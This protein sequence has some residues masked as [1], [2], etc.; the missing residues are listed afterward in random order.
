MCR[1]FWGTNE[2]F[3]CLHGHI[4]MAASVMLTRLVS[5]RGST[6]GTVSVTVLLVRHQTVE[7]IKVSWRK[8]LHKSR[9][10]LLKLQKCGSY[11]LDDG[12]IM[13]RRENCHRHIDPNHWYVCVID[14]KS[15]QQ[16]SCIFK[17]FKAQSTFLCCPVFFSG[18]RSCHVADW[19]CFVKRIV[20]CRIK[21]LLCFIAYLSLQRWNEQKES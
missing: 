17:P 10:R 5:W 3:H 1:G 7:D 15:N 18:V 16:S 6:K 19:V 20:K 8:E 13:L 11:C 21:E 14:K 9:S 2:V 4:T 12:E